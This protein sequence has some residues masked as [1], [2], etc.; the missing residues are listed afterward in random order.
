MAGEKMDLRKVR[1]LRRKSV[2]KLLR[3]GRTIE[4][5]AQ[6]LGASERT[7]RRDMRALRAASAKRRPWD[8]RP[9]CAAAFIEEAEAALQKVRAAQVEADNANTHM[10]LVKL[11]WAMLIKFIELTAG[12]KAIGAVKQEKSQDDEFNQCTNE[13]LIQRGRELG[14]D[15]GSFE[16]A[17]DA[18]GEVDAELTDPCDLEEAA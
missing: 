7:V 17:L 1:L 9:A 18:A 14:V 13:E 10:N 5:I 15:V 12:P 6:S 11:E 8:D 16:R 4:E 2:S 3:D